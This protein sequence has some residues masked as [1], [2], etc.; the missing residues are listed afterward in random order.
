M[1]VDLKVADNKGQNVK[2]APKEKKELPKEE[3]KKK[4]GFK[5]DYKNKDKG[6][7]PPR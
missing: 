7:E 6:E 5:L 4:N 1:Q 2:E 3:E